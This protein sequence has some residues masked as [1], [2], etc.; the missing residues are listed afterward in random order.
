[1]DA[2]GNVYLSGSLR[3]SID[4]GNGVI[5]NSG[6]VTTDGNSI[7]SFDNNGIARWQVTGTASAIGSITPYSVCVSGP[8]ECYFSSAVSGTVNYDTLTANQ[9]GNYAFVLGKINVPVG[10]GIAE[11]ASQEMLNVFPNPAKNKL[12]ICSRQWAI[13]SVSIYNV[14]GT[15][16]IHIDVPS[17]NS[18]MPVELN[19]SEL[20]SGIYFLKAGNAK[21]KFIVQHE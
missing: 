15:I 4:W 19:I 7:I 21:A 14:L 9:G 10:S 13:N 6:S 8:D 3:G 16:K 20:P 2:S 1:M 11:N 18:L 17:I 12:V 5:T